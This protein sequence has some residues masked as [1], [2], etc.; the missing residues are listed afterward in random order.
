MLAA[1]VVHADPGRLLGDDTFAVR[2]GGHYI[3]DGGLFAAQPAALPSGI[4]TGF[5]AG[6]T[7]QCGCGLSYGLRESWSIDDA[8]SLDWNVTQWDLRMRALVQVRHT[9]G[10]GVLALR[11][12]GGPTIV[13]EH[14]VLI[15]SAEAHNLME[16]SS[17]AMLPAVDLEALVGL[18]VA[19]PWLA[20]ISAGPTIEV[21][22]SNL[23]GGWIAQIG[24][25]WQ[26]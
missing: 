15:G 26:P 3:F 2:D 25:G 14:R 24:V 23:R 17:T 18:H 20:M 19:G 5:G 4:S 21:L 7:R 16:S 12:G 10:R 8:S 6:I 13:H 22:D 9:A 11:L 1:S